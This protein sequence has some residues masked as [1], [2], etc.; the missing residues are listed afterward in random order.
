MADGNGM[1]IVLPG[2]PGYEQA[3]VP[4][5]VDGEA[6]GD[7]N[8]AVR[9]VSMTANAEGADAGRVRVPPPTPAGAFSPRRPRPAPPPPRPGP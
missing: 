8:E 6:R 4:D 2:D 1:R 7:F 5:P 3:P 9:A